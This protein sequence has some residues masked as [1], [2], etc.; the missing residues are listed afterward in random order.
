MIVWARF[1][2]RLVMVLGVAVVGIGCASSDPGTG[3]TPSPTTVRPT[4]VLVTTTLVA[5][6]RPVVATTAAA[7]IVNYKS[8]AEAKAAG[9]APLHR[10]DPGYSTNL[11]RDGDGVACE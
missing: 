5:A 4:S 8:C 2:V 10:G 11:D 3:T 6:P 1:G 9:A 7:V